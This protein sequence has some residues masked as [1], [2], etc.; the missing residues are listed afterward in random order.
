MRTLPHSDSLP[1]LLPEIT[2]RRSDVGARVRARGP[3]PR[4]HN[5]ADS[6]RR[7]TGVITA[8]STPSSNRNW[9]HFGTWPAAIRGN[10]L[11][12]DPGPFSHQAS[13]K[14][15]NGSDQ[16]RGRHRHQPR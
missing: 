8:G 1:H 15:K 13:E 4:W 2:M 9:G 16:S 12:D 11:T 10:D 5:S 14:I 6:G 7:A 3:A